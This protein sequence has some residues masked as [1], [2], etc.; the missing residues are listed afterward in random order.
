MA[1]ESSLPAIIRN[2]IIVFLIQMWLFY[3]VL[4]GALVKESRGHREAGEPTVRRIKSAYTVAH[5]GW[6]T[7][8][9]VLTSW[10]SDSSVGSFELIGLTPLTSDCLYGYLSRLKK[11][12]EKGEKMENF[13]RSKKLIKVYKSLLECVCGKNDLRNRLNIFPIL[14]RKKRDNRFQFLVLFPFWDEDKINTTY[15]L[16]IP[17]AN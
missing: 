12:G 4:D 16:I 1:L 17:P 15:S 2:T 13:F 11:S 7:T 8:P 3:E 5:T 10:G 14:I 9:M 6:S